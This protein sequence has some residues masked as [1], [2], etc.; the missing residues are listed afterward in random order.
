MDKMEKRY[1]TWKE[2]YD[3]KKFKFTNLEIPYSWKKFFKSIVEDPKISVIEKKI[4]EDIECNIVPYPDL[5][6]SAFH[7]TNFKNVNVIF[8]GQD[9][10]FNMCV[11]ISSN[12]N[13]KP[14][15]QQANDKPLPQAT[16]LSFSV[17]IG[18]TYPDSLRNIYTNLEK[19][20]HLMKKQTSGNLEFWAHQGCLML[21]SALTVIIGQKK[22][23]INIWEWFVNKIIQKLSDEKDYL[24]FVLWGNDA[25]QKIKFIDIDKHDV[26]IA[27]HPSGLSCNK[28]LGKYPA[29]MNLDHFGIINEKLK[30]INKKSIIWDI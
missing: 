20:D 11:P 15:P 17:P 14:L 4:N 12:N 29:F 18:M 23:H 21:N 2:K 9:P 10:Y 6:F 27:S 5:I 8:I 19:Y 16:G 25:L 7:F 28:S 26:I 3:K 1:K 30:K 22:C 13:D 24:I